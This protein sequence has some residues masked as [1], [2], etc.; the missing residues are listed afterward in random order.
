MRIQI[1]NAIDACGYTTD[2]IKMFK[3]T[4]S[5]L[6]IYNLKSN[7][8]VAEIGYGTGWL[9][10][11]IFLQHDSLNYY[12]TE[13]YEAYLKSIDPIM[14][15]YLSLRKTPNTNKLI[16]VKGTTSKTNLP[17]D[18]FD[19]II[20]RETF[21]HFEFPNEMLHDVYGVLKK[22]GKLFV[23]EPS[24]EKTFFS[25]ECGANNYSKT[26]LLQFF[27]NNNFQLVA[28]HDL[29]DS[30]GNIPSWYAHNPNKIKPKKIFVFQKL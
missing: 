26:D 23:Y 8:T 11:V 22:S 13:V 10:G 1:R 5:E 20:I 19:K 21:H 29:F 9:T 15:K 4:K 18:S 28:E 3:S 24:V 17:A 14:K 27:T 16:I 7:E 12:A 30:P 2:T 25:K 6:Q